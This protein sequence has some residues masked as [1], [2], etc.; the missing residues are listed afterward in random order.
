MKN[1]A[2]WI[3]LASVAVGCQ[4][5]LVQQSFNKYDNTMVTPLGYDYP[6]KDSF[7]VLSWNVEHFVDFYDN[8]YINHPREDNPASHMRTRII[9]FLEAIREADVDVVILQE[10]EGAA[11]LR[12]LAADSLSD[13]GYQFFADAPSQNWYMNVVVMSRFP[14][15]VLSSYGNVTT[16]VVDH[17]DSL[18]RIETQNQLNTRMWSLDVMAGE[19]YVFLLT[20]LHLKAGRGDRNIGMRLGQIKFLKNQFSA[21]TSRYPDHN[22]LVVGDFN[23]TP[24]S[25]ELQLLLDKQNQLIDPIPASVYSHPADEVKRRLDY[26][27]PNAN[28]QSE[29]LSAEVKYFFTPQKMRTISDHLPVM[30]VFKNKDVK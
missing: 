25:K 28:M 8:P 20:G 15:G 18:G 5:Q 26:I 23:A 2:V 27:L 12:Q 6:E 22:I 4:Q 21:V 10:F 9:P 11:F 16:P 19:D 30:A 13:M 7:S 17:L 1:I 14:L 29:L 24:D 3:L